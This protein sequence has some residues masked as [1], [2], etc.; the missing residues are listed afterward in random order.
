MSSDGRGHTLRAL[1]DPAYAASVGGS[2]TRPWRID[3]SSAEAILLGMDVAAGVALTGWS[4]GAGLLDVLPAGP[5]DT[6]RGF[7]T[8]VLVAAPIGALRSRRAGLHPARGFAAALAAS[9]S[10]VRAL[11]V[12]LVL[13]LAVLALCAALGLGPPRADAALLPPCLVL[14][15][16]VALYLV[17]SRL[18]WSLTMAALV[19]HG[20][21]HVRA[22]IL[23][24][25]AAAVAAALW[26]QG[27]AG[28]GIQLVGAIDDGG[29]RFPSPA[30]L[31]VLGALA[32]VVRIAQQHDIELLVVAPSDGAPAPG[33]EELRR[34]PLRLYL[35][36]PEL[37]LF[38]S[39]KFR[40][41]VAGGRAV[42]EF[43][44]MKLQGANALAKH[45]F[46]ILVSALLLVWLAPVLLLI[47]L[48]IRLDSRGPV[49]FRQ[50]RRGF[51]NRIFRIIKFRTMHEAE[52]DLGSTR[53]TGRGDAR[54]TRVGAF[55]RRHSLDELP[56]L[57]NVLCGDMSLVGP[58]PHALLT[59]AEGIPLEQASRAY[60][61]R[62]FVRPGITGLAQ[63]KGWR[64]ELDSLAKL[65]A[66][67]EYDIAY[68]EDWSF[69]MDMRILLQT[70]PCLIH[71]RRAW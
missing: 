21:V 30:G 27:H 48:A 65:H 66:R 31:T 58:R 26:A 4:L 52:A 36:G 43:D 1:P 13:L 63:V 37:T 20:V 57:L 47:A 16:W 64:G 53:Q 60:L 49:L 15:G 29:P 25:G 8:G 50:P 32:D 55:L 6:L 56:Q 9:A 34:L 62:T 23:G 17:V 45:G 68:I 51:R 12:V 19:R 3:R 69:W 61:A 33:L 42:V 7:V 10:G 44:R 22:A 38:P 39:S 41:A 46:D 67:V 28:R 2:G 14:L 24:S 40:L 70:M 54:L 11:G 71:D 59:D 5:D 18:L 35:L